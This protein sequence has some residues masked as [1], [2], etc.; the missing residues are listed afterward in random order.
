MNPI[1]FNPFSKYT[2]KS[3]EKKPEIK[4]KSEMRPTIGADILP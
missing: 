4:E 3:G 1:G 2:E